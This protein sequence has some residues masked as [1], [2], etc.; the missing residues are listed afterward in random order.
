MGSAERRR[1]IRRTRRKLGAFL[2]PRL[3][4]T[5]LRQLS[6]SWQVTVLG[7][8]HWDRAYAQPGMLVTLWHGRMIVPLT[9]HRGKKVCV[10]VSPS[11]DGQLVPPILKKFGFDWVWGSSNKNPARAVREMLERLKTGGRIVITPDGPRGP[12][13]RVNPGPAWMARETGFP[14]LALGCAVDRAWHLS[15]WDHF[16]I[17]KWRARVALVYS[18]PLYVPAEAGDDVIAKAS[19]ELRQRLLAAEE[20]GFRHLGVARDW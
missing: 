10:L 7:R 19:E 1:W 15:S 5:I 3:A 8:E 20:E 11:G 2:L 9:A 12:H 17:P 13:H 18:E 6:S 16:T 14:L 4:P